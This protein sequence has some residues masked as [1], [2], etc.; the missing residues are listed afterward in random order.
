[1]IALGGYLS[2][3][4]LSSMSSSLSENVK[5]DNECIVRWALVKDAPLEIMQ[6]CH[7]DLLR[8]C[9]E[10]MRQL[11][12]TLSCLLVGKLCAGHLTFTLNRSSEREREHLA[13]QHLHT[14]LVG[15]RAAG[16]RPSLEAHIVCAGVQMCLCLHVR[17]NAPPVV[18]MAHQCCS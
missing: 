13:F 12:L 14:E 7:F 8:E 1:M 5:C 9:Y 11:I 10:F 16:W 2:L 3:A 15:A 18:V 4:K 17:T 6:P